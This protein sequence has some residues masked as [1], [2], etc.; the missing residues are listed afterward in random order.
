M[1]GYRTPGQGMK[2]VSSKSR[3][4]MDLLG[5]RGLDS[6]E[7]ELLNG[8]VAMGFDPALVRTF[9]DADPNRRY[10][11]DAI[12]R[13]LR[14]GI[15]E[16]A[17]RGAL[18]SIRKAAQGDPQG[19]LAALGVADPN[20]LPAESRAVYDSIAN[21]QPLPFLDRGQI[22]PAPPPSGDFRDQRSGAPMPAPAAPAPPPPAGPAPLQEPQPKAGPAGTLG[23]TLAGKTT[24]GA[25]SPGLRNLP[26]LAPNAS[27]EEV[28]KY[29]RKWYGFAAWILDVP[30]LRAEMIGL[31]RDFAG[32]PLDELAVEGRMKNT[33]W[34]KTHEADERKA[35]EEKMTDPATYNAGVEG[36][37]R[38][39]ASLAG[40]LGFTPNEAR[41]R[42]IARTG[43]DLGWSEV[44]MRSALAA[45]FDYNPETGQED[46]SRI[47]ADLRSQ[48]SDYLVPLSEQTIDQWG[49]QI[50]AG[51]ST[52]EDFTAYAKSMAKGMFAHYANDI[53]A[54]R[55]VKQ[56]ADPFIQT[57]A[58]DLE[59]TEDQID[60]MDP[61]WRKALELDPET[62]QPMQLSKW[63][64]TIR[65]DS[66]YGWDYTQN[67]RAEAS[68]FASKIAEAFGR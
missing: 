55:T 4:V 64:R 30:D 21:R 57:A 22:A 13:A 59:L 5:D 29:I 12:T 63:Q 35:I 65:S 27:E 8:L 41:L 52:N 36:K 34:W 10:L 62:G 39:L 60:L 2:N 16:Y 58:R 48:A 37:F 24:T 23:G 14:A 26:T 66:S 50:I 19:A 32:A 3:P 46:Q 49:R 43:Y 47:V 31:A 28:T 17:I 44:E 1:A 56:I 40:Q 11:N 45:E 18:D 9:A 25:A 15:P 33:A 53:D 20:Q 61:R 7:A 6:Q 51:T 42:N 67:A 38:T 68:E 54:G